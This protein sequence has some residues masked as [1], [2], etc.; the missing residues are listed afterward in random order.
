MVLR[1]KVL[2]W[3]YTK[4]TLLQSSCLMKRGALLWRAGGTLE[5]ARNHFQG[6]QGSEGQPCLDPHQLQRC[7][8]PLSAPGFVRLSPKT[9]MPE[10]LCHFMGSSACRCSSPSTAWASPGAWEAGEEQSILRWKAAPVLP[11]AAAAPAWAAHSPLDVCLHISPLETAP[12][13]CLKE[14]KVLI[15]INDFL[16]CIKHTGGASW[17]VWLGCPRLEKVFWVW[18]PQKCKALRKFTWEQT[19]SGFKLLIMNV[20]KIIIEIPSLRLFFFLIVL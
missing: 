6:Q 19:S 5:R 20:F 11:P 10:G 13:C 15:E 4:V 17:R 18:S 7:S 12:S 14:F 2:F 8:H 9:S 1:V 16:E 3:I